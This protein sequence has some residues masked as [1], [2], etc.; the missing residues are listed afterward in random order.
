MSFKA[1]A[2]ARSLQVAVE[3]M[4]RRCCSAAISCVYV[5]GAPGFRSVGGVCV[6]EALRTCQGGCGTAQRASGL[7]IQLAT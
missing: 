1:G 3:D 4:G 2:Q 7:A 6:P 5:L